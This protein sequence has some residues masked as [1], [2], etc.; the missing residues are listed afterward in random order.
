MNARD[1]RKAIETAIKH[2]KRDINFKKDRKSKL[3]TTSLK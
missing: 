1:L 2:I 3:K